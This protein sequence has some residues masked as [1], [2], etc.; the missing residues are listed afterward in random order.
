[1]PPEEFPLFIETLRKPLPTTF[2]ITAYSKF[3]NLIKEKLESD[4]IHN[5]EQVL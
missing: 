5:R 2:R 1:M 4:Y 3:A